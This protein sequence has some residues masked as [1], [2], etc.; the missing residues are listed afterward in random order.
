M[1]L[2]IR[3]KGGKP[4]QDTTKGLISLTMFSF[5]SEGALWEAFYQK[6]G[7]EA[8]PVINGVMSRAGVEWGKLMQQSLP[9]KS[10]KSVA[11]QQKMMGSLMGMELLDVSDDSMH[12][13]MLRCPMGLEGTSRE[14][15]EA[16]M[17]VDENRYCTFWGQGVDMKVLQ[18]V[19][20]GDRQCEVVFAKK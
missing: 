20:A 2:V 7:K 11:E 18:T 17:A 4:M 6:Y 1:K 9:V 12:F 14:L 15:C 8:L 5:L 13:K 16:V 3:Q 19:A 10:L